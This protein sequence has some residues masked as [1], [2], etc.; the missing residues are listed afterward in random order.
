M[1]ASF[2]LCGQ[3]AARHTRK[4]KNGHTECQPRCEF[5]V[6][7]SLRSFPGTTCMKAEGAQIIDPQHA[8][9]PLMCFCSITSLAICGQETRLACWLAAFKRRTNCVSRHQRSWRFKSSPSVVHSAR[10]SFHSFQEEKQNGA[11][12]NGCACGRHG[13]RSCIDIGKW[14]TGIANSAAD[15]CR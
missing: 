11:A 7:R 12:S 13:M 14:T 1:E 8:S 6:R 3:P 4:A 9:P 5:L 10:K 15:H 2:D